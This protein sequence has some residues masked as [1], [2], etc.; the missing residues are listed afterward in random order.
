MTR[1]ACEPHPTQ[2]H[3]CPPTPPRSQVQH[4]LLCPRGSIKIG[5]IRPKGSKKQAFCGLLAREKDRYG[6]PSGKWGWPQGRKDT[7]SLVADVLGCPQEIQRPGK[8]RLWGPRGDR[9]HA[10]GDN[11]SPGDTGSRGGSAMGLWGDRQHAQGGQLGSPGDTGSPRDLQHTQGDSCGPQGGPQEAGMPRGSPAVA[12]AGGAGGGRRA[13]RPCQARGMRP[14]RLSRDRGR[15]VCP[16]PGP[17]RWVWE[18]CRC[19][20][21]QP[22]AAAPRARRGPHGPPSKK[23]LFFSPI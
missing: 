23:G 20:L 18:S 17:R 6:V 5:G 14:S 9:Q 3:H 12:D 4:L 7:G 15:P 8:G 13:A 21:G 11:R 2:P 19:A 22:P 16:R 1:A 10:W